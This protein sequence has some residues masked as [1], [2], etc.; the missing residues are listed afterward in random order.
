MFDSIDLLPIHG[1]RCIVQSGNKERFV[2]HFREC[3]RRMPNSAKKGITDFWKESRGGLGPLIVLSKDWESSTESFAQVTLG[4]T[5]MSFC[6]ADFALIPEGISQCIIARA[7]ACV[8][9]H[10]TAGKNKNVPQR[11]EEADEIAESWGFDMFTCNYFRTVAGTTREGLIA[12][13]KQFL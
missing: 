2:Y 12:A 13:C 8:F 10:A 3:W 5:E 6:A 9:Q 4:G 7:L 11:E 1:I